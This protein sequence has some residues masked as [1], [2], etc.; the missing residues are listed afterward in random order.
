[1]M[2]GYTVVAPFHTHPN[3][4]ADGWDPG[5]SGPD[6]L[7]A[8]FLGVPIP[9]HWFFPTGTLTPCCSPVH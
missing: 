7:S 3:P 6:T 9:L 8:S 4:T 2:P 5:P 1:M